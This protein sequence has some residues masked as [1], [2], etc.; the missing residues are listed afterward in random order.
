MGSR[1][2]DTGGQQ[3]SLRGYIAR[4]WED[5]QALRISEEREG[6]WLQQP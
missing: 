2:L 6:P 4:Q 5:Y 3:L 1:R